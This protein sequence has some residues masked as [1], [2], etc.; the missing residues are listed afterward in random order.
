MPS[1]H[2]ILCRPLLL[3][4]SVFPNGY[5]CAELAAA[6][7]SRPPAFTG[8]QSLGEGLPGPFVLKDTWPKALNMGFY[9][10]IVIFALYDL[11]L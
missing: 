7:S 3:P 8:S 4:P 2:L 6:P 11:L 9:I 1:N 5:V 10:C